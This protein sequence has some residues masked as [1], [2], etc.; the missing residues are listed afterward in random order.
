MDALE[1]SLNVKA[2]SI[3]IWLEPD[4]SAPAQSARPEQPYRP[5]SDPDG[6]GR[7]RFEWD[8]VLNHW[9]LI[10][11]DFAEHYGIRLSI[12]PQTWR[13]FSTLVTGLLKRPPVHQVGPEGVL[14]TMQ[15]TR[16][17]HA[18]TPPEAT[19]PKQPAS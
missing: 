9:P 10:E 17:G 1:A 4:T 5:G 12:T 6:R 8:N 16:L 13:E 19:A 3:P 2:T 7:N 15:S 18:L 14:L 11:A